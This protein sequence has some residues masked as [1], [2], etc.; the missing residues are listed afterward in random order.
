MAM[1]HALSVAASELTG[2]DPAEPVVLV[3]ARRV[4]ARLST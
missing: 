1:P 3:A 4:Q 2:A